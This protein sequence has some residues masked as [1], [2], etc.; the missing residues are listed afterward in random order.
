[1]TNGMVEVRISVDGGPAKLIADVPAHLASEYAS[2]FLG[3][4][5]WIDGVTDEQIDPSR[6]DTLWILDGR[7][8]VQYQIH[9]FSQ[10]GGAE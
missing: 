7:E 9:V 3:D 1:M 6:T 4:G 10:D 2:Q 5:F 8:S